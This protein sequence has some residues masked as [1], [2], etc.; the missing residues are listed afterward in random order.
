MQSIEECLLLY[1]HTLRRLLFEAGIPSNPGVTD[2]WI[3]E[4]ISKVVTLGINSFVRD[5]PK[6]VEL[7]KKITAIFEA[8]GTESFIPPLTRRGYIFLQEPR[9]AECLAFIREQFG[10]PV[11]DGVVIYPGGFGD[12]EQIRPAA[13]AY[14]A[15]LKEQKVECELLI[16]EHKWNFGAYVFV[17]LQP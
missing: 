9:D 5:E 17:P 14:E 6:V 4:E 13:E 12:W 8:A 3:L 10:R 15:T 11:E 7:K 16:V 1:R 2:D